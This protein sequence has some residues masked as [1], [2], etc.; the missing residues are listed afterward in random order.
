MR[1]LITRL[2]HIGDCILTLP[3]VS[4]IRRNY[5]AAF[6]VWAVESPSQQLL[7]LHAGIDEIVV[8]PKNWL[9][10]PTA[11][12][13]LSRKLRSFK[14]DTVI[15]PQCLTKS[16]MLGRISGA[17]KRIGLRGKKGRELSRLLNNC[18]VTSPA[19]HVVDRSLGLLVELGINPPMQSE[20]R[21]DLPICPEAK[22]FIDGFLNRNGLTQPARPFVVINPGASWASKRW[23]T[24]RFATVAGGLFQ[25]H[26]IRSVVTWAG[27]EELAMAKQIQSLFP[28]GVVIAEKTNL[29]EL[30]ALCQQAAFFIG[31]DTGPM[32]LAA[33]MGTACVG[34][35]GTTRPTESGAY[36]SQ[37]IAIQ[38]WYQGGKSKQRRKAANDAMRDIFASDVLAACEQMIRS[39]REVA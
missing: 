27:E 1:I 23:E 36:G 3:M 10:S 15:D 37:H 25:Q 17:K 28:T 14:F 24:E 21:F 31:C 30:A 12:S 20:V 19:S 18:L 8:V 29:R 13:S 16:A 2:S 26:A 11:W 9:T 33:A 38:K 32:H 34:L 35:Y 39:R 6:I 4:A 5:P 7:S 22:R